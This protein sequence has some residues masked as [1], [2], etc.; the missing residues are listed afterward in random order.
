MALPGL[1]PLLGGGGRDGKPPLQVTGFE[2]LCI[3]LP[4]SNP[5][6]EPGQQLLAAPV[7]CLPRVGSRWLLAGLELASLLGQGR[8]RLAHHVSKKHQPRTVV[9]IMT[10]LVE[11]GGAAQLQ[12]RVIGFPVLAKPLLNAQE[13]TEAIA[14]APKGCGGQQAT[15]TAIAIVE[16]VN[17]NKGGLHTTVPNPSQAVSLIAIVSLVLSESR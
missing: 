11:I 6:P 9:R 17:G 14:T 8:S 10:A 15:A 7:Q 4:G 12:R 16:G 2:Q 5:R 3:S 1:E 13:P